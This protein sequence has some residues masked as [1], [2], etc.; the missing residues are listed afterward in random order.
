M[1]TEAQD[2]ATD[3]ADC[4]TCEDTSVCPYCNGSGCDGDNDDL[5]ADECEECDGSGDCPDC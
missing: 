2:V 4:S 3:Y 5:D 1:S